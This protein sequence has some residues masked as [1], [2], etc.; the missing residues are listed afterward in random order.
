MLETLERQ[1]G[2]CDETLFTLALL[3]KTGTAQ[4]VSSAIRSSGTARRA[5]ESM[6]IGPRQAGSLCAAVERE[7]LV[8]ERMHTRFLVPG[9][10]GWPPELNDSFNAPPLLYV[11]GRLPD[12]SRSPGL[13]LVGARQATQYGLR[14]TRWLSVL[15]TEMGGVVVSGGATGIDT[16]AHQACLEK[17]GITVC[18][19]GTGIARPYPAGNRGLFESVVEAGGALVSEMP[20]DG[21]TRPFSF[22]L[23]NR[24][25]AGLSSVVVVAQAGENS[26]ALH[27]ARF[28]LKSGRLLFTVPAPIDEDQYRGG[29]KLLE[30]GVPALTSAGRLAHSFACAGGAAPKRAPLL[31]LETKRKAVSASQLDNNVRLALEHLEQGPAHMDDLAGLLALDHGA[32]SLLLMEMELAGWVEKTAGNRYLSVVHVER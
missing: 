15:W 32:V 8:M 6:E 13:A 20:M 19:Q 14:V 11:R 17:G 16:A 21:P 27:T 31:A 23:R 29:L 4:Q 1:F 10:D 18:V 30:E 3:L 22:P 28:A 12:F 7:L 26:G 9:Q 24:I 25:I 5:L 2:R